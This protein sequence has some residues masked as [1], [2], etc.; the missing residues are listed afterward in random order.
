MSSRRLRHMVLL[1]S[2]GSCFQDWSLSSTST[3]GYGSPIVPG[4]IFCTHLWSKF[5]QFAFMAFGSS[6]QLCLARELVSMIS[7][8]L[9]TLN[10]QCTL[11]EGFNPYKRLFTKKKTLICKKKRLLFAKKKTL[12]CR[13]KRPLFEKKRPLF[14]KL[15]KFNF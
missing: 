2:C 5:K 14:L 4:F 9:T 6:S 13:K 8:A 3:S 11:V 1:G 7:G 15:Y 12:I 10:F